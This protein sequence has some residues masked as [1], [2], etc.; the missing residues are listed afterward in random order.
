M[1]DLQGQIATL[2]NFIIQ[3]IPGEPSRDEGAV[4]TAIRLLG[5]YRERIGSLERDLAAAKADAESWHQQMNDREETLLRTGAERD[6]ALARIAE[7]ENILTAL[8]RTAEE[9]RHIENADLIF[10]IRCLDFL[11]TIAVWEAGE[12]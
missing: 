1:I 4:E 7:F 11:K 10:K 8:R 2:G 6:V 9:G 3:N 5:F 12:K